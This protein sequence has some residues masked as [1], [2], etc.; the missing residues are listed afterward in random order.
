MIETN[1]DKPLAEGRFVQ[2]LNNR[3]G[4]KDEDIRLNGNHR[5]VTA[6]QS[7]PHCFTHKI[8]LLIFSSL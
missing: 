8:P 2:I 7:K 1:E 6:I 3:L 4:I 5:H